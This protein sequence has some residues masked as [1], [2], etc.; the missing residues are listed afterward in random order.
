MQ[1][2]PVVKQKH[3]N[4]SQELMYCLFKLDNKYKINKNTISG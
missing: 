1:K 4:Q 2:W 3:I